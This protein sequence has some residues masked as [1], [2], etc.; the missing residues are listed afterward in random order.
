[1]SRLIHHM[2]IV[3]GSIVCLGLTLSACGASTSSDTVAR[4]GNVPVTKQMVTRWE[5]ISV[6]IQNFTSPAPASSRAVVPDP[7]KFTACIASL[8]GPEPKATPAQLKQE[9]QTKY[10]ELREATTD[11]LINADWVRGEAAEEGIQVSDAEVFRQ[12]SRVKQQ[13]FPKDADFQKFLVTTHQ[14]S[15]DILFAY[16]TQA[17]DTKLSEKAI[18]GK[19]GTAAQAALASVV[20]TFTKKW[21][22]RTTCIPGYVFKDC[23]QSK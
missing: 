20:Q 7:P 17:L 1:M 23:K 15:A 2:P 14:T 18:Q 22:A 4:V 6:G 21:K 9:C 19:S 13:K 3:L 10:T 12:F 5:N 8:R 16:K 11:K